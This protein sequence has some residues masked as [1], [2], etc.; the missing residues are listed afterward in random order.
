MKHYQ[1]DMKE[2]KQWMEPPGRAPG[3]EANFASGQTMYLHH[4]TWHAAAQI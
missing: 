1:C 2:M 3:F 4:M